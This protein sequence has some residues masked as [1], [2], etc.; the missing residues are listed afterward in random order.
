MAKS[1]EMKGTLRLKIT[2]PGQTNVTYEGELILSSA[3]K[4]QLQR[5]LRTTELTDEAI[6]SRFTK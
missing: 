3:D 5:D 2:N 6:R 1:V 4:F